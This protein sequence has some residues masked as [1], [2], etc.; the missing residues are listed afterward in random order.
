MANYLS[1]PKAIQAV[2][3]NRPHPS[4]CWRWSTRGIGGVRLKTWVVGGRRMTTT[5]AVETFIGTRTEL[6]TPSPLSSNRS[7]SDSVRAELGRELNG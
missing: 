3:G 2:T 4:T 5:E 1:V 7:E 6:A